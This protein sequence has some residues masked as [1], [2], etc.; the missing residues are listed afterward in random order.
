MRNLIL[1]ICTW[2]ILITLSTQL[3]I[4]GKKDD[5]IIEQ[6]YE[7]PEIYIDHIINPEEVEFEEPQISNLPLNENVREKRHTYKILESP[8][9][10]SRFRQVQDEEV[11]KIKPHQRRYRR[12]TKSKSELHSDEVEDVDDTSA[13][14][15]SEGSDYS[16]E[17]I[18]PQAQKQTMNPAYYRSDDSRLMDKW[19]KAPYG[20]FQARVHKEEDDSQSEQSS[21]VGIKTRTPRVNFITQQGQQ[22][23]SSGGNKDEIPDGP[24]A[25]EREPE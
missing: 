6:T 7:Q 21:N 17:T 1:T 24:E 11:L 16:F 8:G 3:A 15:K 14:K 5:E 25:R 18:V 20:D 2:Q 10:H 22:S 23:G 13:S 9:L 4:E 12:S 19:V